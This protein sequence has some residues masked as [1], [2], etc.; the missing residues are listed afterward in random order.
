MEALV[1]DHAGALL[2]GALSMGFPRAEA[3][4]LVQ[5]ALL[6]FV[7]SPDQFQGRSSLRTYLYGILYK[8]G[9]E[10]RRKRSRELATDPVDQIF[11]KR[12]SGPMGHWVSPPKGPEDQALAGELAQ[13]IQECM[14]GL[15]DLQKA[16][17]HLKEVEHLAG[18]DVCNVLE[19]TD[20]HLRVALFRARI[21]LRNC[22]EE[23]SI[24]A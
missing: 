12:M 14:K 23:K 4:D 18:K 24:H 1:K 2:C 5:E 9:L 7:R 17:F 16:A 19:V 10:H 15:S 8:K 21:K 3:E 6:V 11:E 13:L 22:L 20:N